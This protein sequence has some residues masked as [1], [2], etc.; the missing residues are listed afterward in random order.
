MA[1]L[2]SRLRGKVPALAWRDE[3]LARRETQVTALREDLAAEQ[4]RT[5]QL[6]E[7]LAKSRR[8]R[9]NLSAQLATDRP[10]FLDSSP[11]SFRRHLLDL[12]RT[13]E[14]LRPLDRQLRHPLLQIPRKLRNYELAAS[15]G[16]PVPQILASWADLD[17]MDLTDLPEEFVLKSDGGAGGAGVLP[18]RR[19]P[20]GRFAMIGGAETFTAE[21]VIE[22][23]RARS[24]ARP[25][26]FAEALLVQ[27]GGGDLPDDI[28]IYAF[29]G[30]IGHVMLRRMVEHAN[31]ASAGFRYLDAEGTDLG[32]DVGRAQQIDP[33]IPA[34]ERLEEFVEIA[35][36]LS[37]A[38]AVPFIRVDVYDTV[39]GPV[40][41]EL[42]R[43][44]GGPQRY[45]SDHDQHMGRL[46]DLAQ[47]R[48]DLDVQSGRP[49]GNLHGEH[50]WTG[51]YPP[52]WVN[53]D[54]GPGTWPVRTVPCAAWCRPDETG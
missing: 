18:L 5:Q 51:L 33:Q 35:R 32:P 42:T 16:I 43:G 8:V 12:R 50:P 19:I 37:R 22:R 26:F 11:A 2:R 48:L 9:K 47:Y 7:Q 3:L 49:M 17:Q 10:E 24:S 6:Q 44:P 30:E 25:P 14:E 15:H 53:R 39:E 4:R 38:M 54:S 20:G 27:P 13:I 21:E 23:Y 29:Y 28:K 34:P 46:W 52:E 41:G 36:H 40:L 45:R 31:V 1:G